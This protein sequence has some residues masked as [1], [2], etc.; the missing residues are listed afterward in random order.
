MKI[1][2]LIIGLFVFGIC[3]SANAQ[4]GTPKVK[5]RQINQQKRIVK[6]VAN[7]ELTKKEYKQLQKDQRKINRAK[8]RAKADGKVTKKEKVR[9]HHNQNKASRKIARKKHNKVDRN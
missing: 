2:S 5:D 8:K 9:L 7:G 1:K 3:L 4:T 6:G